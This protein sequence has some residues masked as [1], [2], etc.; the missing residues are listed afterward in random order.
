[1][2]Y[3]I[4]SCDGGGV[5]GLM[6]AV[7][8]TRLEQKLGGRLRDHFDL[9][10]GTS[11]G[12]ILACAVSHGI[13]AEDIVSMYLQHGREVFP[14]LSDRFFGRLQ[15]TLS[16]GVS[17]PKYDGIGLETVLQ[18]VFGKTSFG[19]LEIRPTLVVSYDTFNRQALVFKNTRDIFASLPVWEVVRAS[20]AAPVYFPGHVM[21]IGRADVPLIDG[22]VVANNPTACAVAEAVRC[23]WEAHGSDGPGI[24]DFVVASFGTGQTT[25]QIG[26]PQV[27]GWGGAEWILPVIDVIFDGVAGSVDYVAKQLLGDESY[28]R[29]QCKLE[30]AYDQMDNADPANLNALVSTAEAYLLQGGERQLDQLVKALQPATAAPTVRA[31][32]SILPAAPRPATAS[33]MSPRA[34]A[35]SPGSSAFGPAVAPPI[36]PELAPPSRPTTPL[37]EPAADTDLQPI[38]SVPSL[39]TVKPASAATAGVKPPARGGDLVKLAFRRFRPDKAA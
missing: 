24:D 30:H 27:R 11:T 19:D 1:M 37:V 8:L 35:A 2:T 36:R 21:K 32:P 7:W 5:R 33:G 28:F 23:N 22:G 38:A 6:T 9:V 26:I 4:L 13:P 31:T 16:D 12:S 15:R 29:F 39:S 18:R 34:T 3:R 20:C 17:A 25:R 14:P 10:A